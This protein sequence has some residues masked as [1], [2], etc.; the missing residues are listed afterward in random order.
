MGRDCRSVRPVA[1]TE[2]R[3][4][5]RRCRDLAE[6]EDRATLR[7]RRPTY[8]PVLTKGA[9]RSLGRSRTDVRR[10]R[11]PFVRVPPG[12][13][14][15]AEGDRFGES[16]SAT[17]SGRLRTRCARRDW[18]VRA[19][20]EGR[21]IAS[22]RGVRFRT[23]SHLAPSASTIRG[24]ALR[25]VQPFDRRE[26]ISGCCSTLSRL[27]ASTSASVVSA[28]TDEEDGVVGGCL[29]RAEFIWRAESV[30][31]RTGR[32]QGTNSVRLPRRARAG[33]G[34]TP[35]GHCG[36]AGSRPPP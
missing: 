35:P 27:G 20:P 14:S 16:G 21:G 12:Q 9:K 18:A 17:G 10:L 4:F 34:R 28:V 11:R 25:I 30:R 24:F 7:N 29:A 31:E 2:S 23:T 33:A 5:G 22:V 19:S 26:L 32:G 1:S 13:R 6:T 15:C 36:R 3:A 8:E